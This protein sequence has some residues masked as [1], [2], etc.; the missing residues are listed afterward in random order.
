MLKQT[1][2]LNAIRIRQTVLN[3]FYLLFFCSCLIVSSEI[4]FSESLCFI[5][6]AVHF[7]GTRFDICLSKTYLNSE[8]PS[9]DENLEIPGYN[10]AIEDPVFTIKVRS[11]SR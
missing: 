11:H 1:A 2:L 5:A 9:D 6:K 8:I 4:P 7:C 3:M 10:L